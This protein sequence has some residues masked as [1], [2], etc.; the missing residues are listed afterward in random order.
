M[1][2]KAN[3]KSDIF[4]NIDTE[5]KAY[6]LGFIYADGNIS[7]MK[8]YLKK[9]GKYVY[10]IEVSLMASDINHLNKLKDFLG[11]E[12]EIKISKAG[13]RHERCRLYFNDK[14]MWHRL[15]E[16]GC[17]PVKSLALKFPEKSIFKTDELIRHFIRGYVDGDGCIS[18]CDKAHTAMTLRILGTKHFLENMQY[19]IPLEKDNKITKKDNIYEVTF[20]RGRG[21]YVCNFLYKNCEVYLERKLNR[22]KE[23]CRLYEESYR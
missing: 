18:Y 5:E 21:V 16:I 8:S 12:K 15:N 19:N 3:I 13:N 23:Y 6:W 22:Y 10:R 4:D 11:Y 7:D 20:Q 17:T 9:S 14:H 2:R 1:G